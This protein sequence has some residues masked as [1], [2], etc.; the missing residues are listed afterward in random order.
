MNA[1]NDK[2][3]LWRV[4]HDTKNLP[5]GT[6]LGRPLGLALCPHSIQL[7]QHT[8]SKTCCGQDPFGQRQKVILKE[9]KKLARAQRKATKRITRREIALMRKRLPKLECLPCVKNRKLRGD[10]PNS[11]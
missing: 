7:T 6:P 5:G 11:N 9:L 4:R 3:G 1:V 2:C 8:L 10:F